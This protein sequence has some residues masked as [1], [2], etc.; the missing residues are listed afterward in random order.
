MG[1]GHTK[2]QQMKLFL[3][4]NKHVPSERHEKSKTSLANK[5]F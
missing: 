1:S 3:F 5:P 4:E 2:A